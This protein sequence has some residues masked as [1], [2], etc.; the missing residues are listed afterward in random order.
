M[1]PLR[2]EPT[3]WLALASAVLGLLVTFNFDWLTAQQSALIITAINAVMAVIAVW[4][5]RPIA[6]QVWTYAL[7]SLVAVLAAYGLNVSQE[8]VGQLNLIMLAILGLMTR[9]AVSPVEDVVKG[10]NP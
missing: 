3:L 8:Q 4:R 7:T 10:V 1:N 9:Q 2:R 5:T 6:P